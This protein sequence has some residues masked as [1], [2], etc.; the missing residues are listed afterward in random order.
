MAKNRVFTAE[1]L[2]SVQEDINKSLQRKNKAVA[3]TKF[4]GT[5]KTGMRKLVILCVVVGLIVVGY[6]AVPFLK[7][8]FEPSNAIPSTEKALEWVK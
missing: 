2:N 3:S 1:E 5:S 6:F 8:A 7:V 4:T